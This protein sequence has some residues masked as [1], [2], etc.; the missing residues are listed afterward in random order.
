MCECGCTSNDLRYWFPAPGKKL[1]MLTLSNACVDC[2]APSGVTIELI[3]PNDIHYKNRE[4]YTDGELK[5]ADW[6]DTKGVAIVTGFR[7]HEFIK[8]ITP[9]LIDT[10]LDELDEIGAEVLL[11]EAYEDSV[12]KPHFPPAISTKGEAP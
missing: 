2:D 3:G 10:D 11:E 7:R 4:D 5:F 1:Y 12:V 6:S 8:A 9:H